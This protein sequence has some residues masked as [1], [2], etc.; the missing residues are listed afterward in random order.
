MENW[1]PKFNEIQ[2]YCFNLEDCLRYEYK[3]EI[4]MNIENKFK[5]INIK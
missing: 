1:K 2:I 4:Y 3:I 5:S